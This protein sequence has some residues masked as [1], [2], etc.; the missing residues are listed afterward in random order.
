MKIEMASIIEGYERC[1]EMQTEDRGKQKT[2]AYRSVRKVMDITIRS[3]AAGQSLNLNERGPDTK[4][5]SQ[6]LSLS[7][8]S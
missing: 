8:D 4:T 6:R 3:V 5:E 2:E 7:A 1:E